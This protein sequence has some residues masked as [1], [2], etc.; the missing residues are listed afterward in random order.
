MKEHLYWNPIL[1]KDETGQKTKMTIWGNHKKCSEIQ[2]GVT[3]KFTNLITDNFPKNPPHFLSSKDTT[4]IIESTAQVR[5]SN[6]FTF[7]S[8]HKLQ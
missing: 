8:H 1:V 4:L 2:S 3:Y 5:N 7:K 6:F